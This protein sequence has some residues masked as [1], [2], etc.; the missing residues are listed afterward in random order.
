MFMNSH[1][2]C[3]SVLSLCLYPPLPLFM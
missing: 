3:L 1:Y 2:R